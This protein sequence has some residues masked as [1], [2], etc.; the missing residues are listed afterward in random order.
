MKLTLNWMPATVFVGLEADLKLL[1][2]GSGEPRI[3]LWAVV[4][5]TIQREYFRSAVVGQHDPILRM[6]VYHDEGA[7]GDYEDT[8]IPVYWGGYHKE[9]S[10]GRYDSPLQLTIWQHPQYG[11][12]LV[13]N[14][15]G[16]IARG[17]IGNNFDSS[18]WPTTAGLT[19]YGGGWWGEPE[20]ELPNKEWLRTNGLEED[21][22]GALLLGDR[23][24]TY[25]Q[26]SYRGTFRYIEDFDRSDDPNLGSSWLI[27]S[28]TGN[29]W[30]IA[31]NRG[32][33][34]EAG[35]ERW[36]AYPYCRDLS[37]FITGVIPQNNSA[38][39]L[40][41]RFEWA[42]AGNGI[43]TGYCGYL[44]ISAGTPTLVLTSVVN[45]T[46]TPITAKSVTYT[47]GDTF[48]LELRTIGDQI[49]LYLWDGAVLIDSIT[50]TD[51]SLSYPGAI[52]IIGNTPG[53]GQYVWADAVWAEIKGGLKTRITE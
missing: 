4:G 16:S 53:A 25:G 37:A 49:G 35:V 40:Y 30:N 10:I 48:T 45:D 43:A 11:R 17:I 26:Q 28:Q 12:G 31:S 22:T 1:Q 6:R 39:G 46:P 21:L 34:E 29:G 15:V 32:R 36:S 5:D 52:G 3:E 20:Y 51:S 8:D 38:L 44:A 18:V 42:S 13:I 33:C 24:P 50:A 9:I 19:I 2:I 7:P 27:V 41:S 14:N 23:D 47:P